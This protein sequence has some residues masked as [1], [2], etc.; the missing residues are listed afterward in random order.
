MK[1]IIAGS[2]G[3]IDYFVLLQA[4][5]DYPFSIT[6]VVSGCA[7]GVDTL[8]EQYAQENNLKLYKFP[9]DWSTY[10]KRAGYIRNAEMAENAD[11]LLAIWDGESRGTKHM[12]DIARAKGLE[13]YVYMVNNA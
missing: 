13:V 4:I 12:I 1:T 2:R 9:A 6:S 10:G 11:A 3:I 7:K 5:K 8:G